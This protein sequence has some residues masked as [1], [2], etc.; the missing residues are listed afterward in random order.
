MLPVLRVAQ[1]LRATATNSAWRTSIRSIGREPGRL[2]IRNIVT[3]P[4]RS[5]PVRPIARNSRPTVIGR[6]G[7]SRYN[8]T[9]GPVRQKIQKHAPNGIKAKLKELSQ[10]YGWAAVGVYLGLS[11]LDFPFCFLAVRMLGAE[12]VGQAEHFV[13]DRFWQLVGLVTPSG[14]AQKVEESITPS[15]DAAVREGG[16]VAVETK[17]GEG[18]TI[19]TQLLLAYGV[20][21]SLIFFRVPLTAAVTPRIVKYLRARGRDRALC[22]LRSR[23]RLECT[24]T[25]R[26]PKASPGSV[27][28]TYKKARENPRGAQF[29]IPQI[30]ADKAT[31]SISETST[32]QMSSSDTGRPGSDQ[33]CQRICHVY[34]CQHYGYTMVSHG[35]ACDPDSDECWG[36]VYTT[37]QFH[38]YCCRT[39]CCARDLDAQYRA[40][41]VRITGYERMYGMDSPVARM[42]RERLGTIAATHAGCSR[43]L[44]FC[45]VYAERGRGFYG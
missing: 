36:F 30:G 35:V 17:Q 8:S 41:Q 42:E 10:K 33:I 16:D 5:G 37:E 29:H 15:E 6:L 43:R 21:K 26:G 23:I 2:Q 44:E 7:R 45:R 25:D 1:E 4:I 32:A 38:N 11:A 3:Q 22:L 39:A 20:H 19:W 18:A 14:S 34:R 27:A 31:T 9:D 40:Q 24:I 28:R 12:R 13:V